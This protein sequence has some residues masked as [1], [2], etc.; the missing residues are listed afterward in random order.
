MQLQD[1]GP[2]NGI[3][4]QI[5]SFDADN[6]FTLSLT[7]S[8]SYVR[9]CSA[10]VSFIGGDG[11]TALTV[12]DNLWQKL[13]IGAVWL[14]YKA[15]SEL[16]LPDN[17][18]S[19][20]F[21]TETNTLKFLGTLSAESTFLGVPVSE[22]SSQFTFSLPIDQSDTVS[23]IRV[24]VGSLGIPSGIDWDPKAAAI[25]IGM[26]AFFDLIIPTVSVIATVGMPSSDLFST[27][28]GK[29][30]FFGPAVIS[31]V[32][33]VWDI[34]SNPN[35]AGKDLTNLLTGIADSLMQNVLGAA[36]VAAALAAVFGGEEVAEAIPIVGWALKAEAI[37]A[38]IEQLAQTVGE[39][40]G[41]ARV[42]EFDLTVA[43]DDQFTLVPADKSGFPETATHFTVTAQFSD[44]TGYVYTGQ[45]P[46]PKVAQVQFTWSDMPVG[47]TVSFLVAFYSEEGYLVGK[48]ESPVM[49]NFITTG[50]ASLV[51][52]D[53]AITQL[54][55][56][57][58]AD[59]IYKHQQLLQY[60]NGA[61][62][63][64]ETSSA[65]SETAKD[66]G[67]GEGGN[68]LAALSG[69]TLNSDLGVLG[70]VWEASG[71]N[72]PLIGTSQPVDMQAYT[73]QNISF[74]SDPESAL[75]FVAAGYSASPRLIYLRSA[76]AVDNGGSASAAANSFFYLDPVADADLGYNLRG[77]VPVTDP[78]VPSSS[79]KRIFDQ[80]TDLSWGR[81][82]SPLLPTSLAIHSNGVVVGV[83][84]PYNKLLILNLP[85][86]AVPTG[87]APW[88]QVFSGPGT[89]P[90]L[91]SVPQLVAIAPESDHLRP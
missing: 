11:V 32:L 20:L 74:N 82:P 66:L 27:A 62:E 56:P 31:I 73:F 78:S 39:V 52:P 30:S 85:D 36:D 55:Y 33:A 35:M 53:I 91:L 29:V 63:W 64:L 77:I 42:T 59:T 58:S 45:F 71:Q 68:V 86:S 83:A 46:D 80:S 47:G 54:L 21:D 15:W 13:A 25:G 12:P 69:V 51:V 88:S 22:G 44:V 3:S 61:H 67:T 41:S 87:S 81:F 2:T 24:L 17:E 14:A 72:V 75:M 89:R 7:V 4:A 9:H 38:T 40:V 79:P 48:G 50:Q 26:T 23:K 37:E 84:S 16:E 76:A 8:N 5:E 65:P 57:L 43:M 60:A 28:F 90:G 6:G 18:M 19:M 34:I 10:F 70:Y 1:P 49:A